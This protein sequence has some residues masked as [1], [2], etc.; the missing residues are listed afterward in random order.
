M[1]KWIKK[2]FKP[3]CTCDGCFHNMSGKWCDFEHHCKKK[4]K[5]PD[6]KTDKR[7]ALKGGE[8]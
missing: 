7:L 6:K 5:E 4:F 1:S 3:K 2:L 8:G